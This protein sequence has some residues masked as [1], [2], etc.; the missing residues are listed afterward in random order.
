MFNFVIRMYYFSLV[1][2]DISG[3]R[4]TMSDDETFEYAEMSD[5]TLT[6]PV[7]AAAL[8]RGDHIVIRGR[9]CR[10]LEVDISKVGKHGH[11]K[12]CIV[13]QDIFSAEKLVLFFSCSLELERRYKL[14]YFL[15]SCRNIPQHII[16]HFRISIFSHCST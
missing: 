12:A 4:M 16:F 13:A 11:T 6:F 5:S 14:L 8:K 7:Q 3:Y 9:A 10:I 2:K 15:I 1:V